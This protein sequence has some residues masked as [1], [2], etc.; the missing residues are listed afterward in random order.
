[1]QTNKLTMLVD[2][3]AEVKSRF[4]AAKKD[5]DDRGK[6][7]KQIM[8]DENLDSFDTGSYTAKFTLQRRETMDEGK[9]IAI[10]QKRGFDGKIV[11]LKPYVDMDALESAIY[12]D[13]LPKEVQDELSACVIVKEIPTLKVVKNKEVRT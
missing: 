9:V 10:L 11:K 12:H 4:E 13:E 8:Q 2:A 6:E 5:V 3:F 1:M 7:I